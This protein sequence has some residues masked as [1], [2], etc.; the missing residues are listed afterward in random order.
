MS[1]LRARLRHARAALFPPKRFV[2]DYERDTFLVGY[3]RSGTTWLS[4]IAVDLLYG[5]SPDKLD[6]IHQLVPDVHAMPRE[7]SVRPARN[8]LVKSHLELKDSLDTRNYK[9]VIYLV[10]DPRDV[11][12]S[13]YRFYV[14]KNDYQ[15]PLPQFVEDW[16]YGRVWPCSW[17]EHVASWL[18][19][20]RNDREHKLLLM[21]YEDLVL[22]PEP[23]IARLADFIGAGADE[24]KVR[25]ILARTQP[26]AMRK[27][28]M[29]ESGPDTKPW[30]IGEAKPGGWRK[31]LDGR[32]A[33]LIQERAQAEMRL[34]GYEL[35]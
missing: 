24:A 29:L 17:Q 9:K 32:L 33:H 34:V 18:G 20:N 28:E 3:P 4:Y 31:Q 30:F 6:E 10:R 15:D 14:S 13:Y 19:S 7:N 1:L 21:R 25:Q 8:Y 23:E 2:P 35:S 16:T 27:R 12:L 11:V 26:D 5:F 22:R